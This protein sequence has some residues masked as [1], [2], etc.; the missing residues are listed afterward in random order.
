[1]GHPVNEDRFRLLVDGQEVPIASSYD[2]NAGV[3]EVPSNFTMQVGHSGLL[4]DL[5]HGYSEFTPFELLVNDVKVMVGEIDSHDA[6]TGDATELKVSGRDRLARLYDTDVSRDWSFENATFTDLVEAALKEVGL[7]EVSVVSDNLAN[8]KAITGKYKVSELVDPS[9]ESTDT[10][11][12]ETVKRRTK[13]VNRSLV[14]EAGN[15][16]WGFLTP[17]F[18]RGGLFLWAD[19]FGGFVLGQPNG[20]QAPSY[21]ILRRSNGRGEGGDVTILGRPEYRRSTKQRHSHYIVEGR[22]GTGAD[23]RDFARATKVDEEM[24]ALL[25]PNEAD[26]AN[27]GKRQRPKFYRDDKVKTP[28]QA[29]FLALRKMAQARREGFTLKYTVSGHSA[30]ALAGGGRLVWTPDTTVH[31]VDEVLGIDEVMYI[32]D[33]AFSRAV[34]TQSK[35]VVSVM[36]TDDLLFGDEDLLA[37]PPV[38]RAS[39]AVRMGRTEVFHPVWVKNPNWG[40]LPTRA[41][42]SDTGKEL[43]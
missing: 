26:R 29:S 33:C 11:L 27:G 28:E 19:V 42:V 40:N 15:T 17:Q 30:A 3:F 10:E 16:W 13:T 9:Q 32:D 6:G 31:V 5:I 38:R 25:N 41:W 12:G 8:R 35:T 36:R 1:M 23:G 37:P 14:M 18:Q 43:K 21:R 4:A 20:K 39:S 2:V 24:V 7:G 22:K 34:N